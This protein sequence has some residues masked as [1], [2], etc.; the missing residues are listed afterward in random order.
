VRGVLSFFRRRLLFRLYLYEVLL[1]GVLLASIHTVV[2]LVLEPQLYAARSE[3]VGWAVEAV[4]TLRDQPAKMQHAIAEMPRRTPLSMTLYDVDGSVIASNGPASRSS[5]DAETKRRLEGGAKIPRGPDAVLVG[6]NEGG[7]LTAYAQ[8]TFTGHLEPA[9]NVVLVMSLVLGIIA[10]G[11]IP[12]ARSIALPLEKLSRVTRDFGLGDLRARTNLTRSDEIGRVA[13]SFDQMADRIESLR[14]AEKELLANVSHELRTPLARIRVVVELAAEEDADAVKGYLENI[15]EDLVEVEQILD[16]IITTARLDLANERSNDPFPP[17]R[18]A[19]VPVG[20]LLE[21]LLARFGEQHPTRRLEG[22]FTSGDPVVSVDRVMLKHAISN[23]LDNADKYSPTSEPIELRSRVI[24]AGAFLEISVTDRGPGMT[25]DDA[26]R[27]FEP[28]FRQ[29]R[30][31]TRET[32]GV[33]LGLTLAKR[34]VEAHGGFIE[35]RTR[36]GEGA[37]VALTIPARRA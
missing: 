30:S 1:I 4:A 5:F 15:G 36:P 37:T 7:R 13:H 29:D 14:R 35:I 19:P 26:A 17:L 8:V 16:D 10:L 20:Q 27:A 2:K 11:S 33:G 9:P 25:A 23:L 28:F 21:S 34:I 18:L 6:V 24:E 32:G 3:A 12:L 22:S 31:R